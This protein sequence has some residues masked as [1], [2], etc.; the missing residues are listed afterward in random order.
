MPIF[1][2]ESNTSREVSEGEEWMLTHKMQTQEVMTQRRQAQRKQVRAS[3]L[4]NFLISSSDELSQVQ[5]VILNRSVI[6]VE[7]SMYF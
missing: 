3:P 7:F 4:M 2:D 1:I 5:C 6:N